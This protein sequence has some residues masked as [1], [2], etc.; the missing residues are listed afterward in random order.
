MEEEE[1]RRVEGWA[2]G[3]ARA[4][5]E[6]GL[7]EP[8]HAHWPLVALNTWL[9]VLCRQRNRGRGLGKQG[10]RW[11]R[12]Q[13]EETLSSRLPGLLTRGVSCSMKLFKCL[14][15]ALGTRVRTAEE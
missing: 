7:S 12:N 8:A 13:K 2:R 15:N 5:L 10:E 14:G 4:L 6:S 3:K 9:Y 11:E 1:E